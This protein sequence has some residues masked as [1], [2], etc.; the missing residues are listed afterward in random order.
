MS[1]FDIHVQ[2]SLPGFRLDARLQTDAARVVIIG[3]SGS[4]KTLFMQAVAGLYRPDGGHIRICERVF[5]DGTTNLPTAR[6]NVAYLFQDYALFPH[7]TVAQNIAFGLH[8]GWRNPG[9]RRPH[10]EVAAWL[11]RLHIA[12]IAHA[13]SAQLSG[14]QKQRTALARALIRRPALLL[15]DEPFSALDTSLRAQM[16]QLVGELQREYDVPLLLIT[17]DPADAAALGDVV[18]QMNRH[19][20][21]SSLHAV[22]APPVAAPEAEIRMNGIPL[23][24]PRGLQLLAALANEPALLPV[25]ARLGIREK[26]ARDT[27]DALNNLAGVALTRRDG[28]TAQ[29][30]PDGHAWLARVQEQTEAFRQFLENQQMNLTELLAMYFNISTRN[31]LKGTISAVQEG[32]VNSEVAISIGAHQLTAIITRHSVERLGLKAGTDAYALIKASDV[33]IG[34]AE[35]AAQISARNVIPG[36]I[37]RIETGAVNDEITLD[38]GDGNSLVAIIT[39]ASAERLNFAVGQNACAI[40][41]ASNVMIGC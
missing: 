10:A 16:R 36:T 28:V 8:E 21:H 12:H 33:M 3:G 39:R 27:L 9:R 37:S 30:T 18:Y 20:E 24:E 14:G 1:R 15:L 38:I 26:D 25:C 6:R 29:L 2:K 40:I 19:G 31:Q 5:Y 17:H 35:V 32:A 22:S 23:A 7:L 34:S 41:K 4:G 11:E 13:Y